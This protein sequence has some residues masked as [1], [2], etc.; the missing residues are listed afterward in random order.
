M[1][2]AISAVDVAP[3]AIAADYH[4][5]PAPRICAQE[6]PGLRPVIMLAP[7]ALVMRQ[8]MTWTRAAAAAMMPLQSCLCTV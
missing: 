3:I 6:Q 7:A 1:G 8:S 5:G 4:L 2:R